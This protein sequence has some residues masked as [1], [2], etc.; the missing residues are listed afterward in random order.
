M[1]KARE[2][3][4]SIIIV[5]DDGS[6]IRKYNISQTG[7][8]VLKIVSVCIFIGIVG[9]FFEYGS[10]IQKNLKIRSL[11]AHNK[12]LVERYGK[13]QAFEEEFKDF[14]SRMLKLSNM[15]G[16][17]ANL[18]N[19]SA[20]VSVTPKAGEVSDLSVGTP[21]SGV[22]S[23][24]PH[25]AP[26]PGEVKYWLSR[27]FSSSHNGMDFSTSAGTTVLSTMSG[28]VSFAG[29]NDTLGYLVKVTNT[30][31]GYTTLYAHL[32]KT[33]VNL[34]DDVSVGATIGY[35][36]STGQSSAPHLHY[37]VLLNGV[38]QNPKLYLSD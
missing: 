27:S 35:V 28:V 1:K 32:I 11:E 15:L 38:A 20:H 3:N 30:N 19:P 31:S 22:S 18:S 8:Q 16:I 2:K 10:I 12:E 36:G 33:A 34:N 14:K 13:L 25:G 17:K 23:V 21:A 29:W 6:K 26:L 37:E 24:R 7:V 9:L 4:Y 5:P